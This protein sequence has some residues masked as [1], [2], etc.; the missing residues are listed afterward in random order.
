MFVVDKS[1]GY[2]LDQQFKVLLP[3]GLE[4]TMALDKC[5][6]Y[7]YSKPNLSNQTREENESNYSTE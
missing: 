5:A 4:F 3:A 2:V 6:V 7:I 1:V